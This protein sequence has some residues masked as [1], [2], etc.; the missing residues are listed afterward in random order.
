MIAMTASEDKELIDE[1]LAFI[2]TDVQ[3]QDIMYFFAGAAANRHA[4]RRLTSFFEENYDKFIKMYEGNFSLSYLIK[5]AYQDYTT[6]EDYAKTEAFFKDKDVSKFNLALAQSLDA[7]R[8]NA[9][10][11]DRSKEDVTTWLEDW[12]KES[13]L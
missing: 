12:R 5:F 1:T 11:L 9:K 6:E 2:L 3:I 8:A 10:W 4:R 13:K 7:V